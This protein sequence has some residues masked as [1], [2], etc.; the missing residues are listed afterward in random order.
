MKTANEKE[1][2][3]L[4]KQ[5]MSIEEFELEVP[6][7]S[8]RARELVSARKKK[9]N[10]ELNLFSALLAF[11]KLDLK[12]YHVGLTV[13]VMF[14]GMLYIKDP[15]YDAGGAANFMDVQSALSIS[16]NTVSVKSS[17][18]LTSIP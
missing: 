5:G 14:A 1:M 7:V 3:R 2:H 6:A 17:T 13:L 8:M 16:N 9:P 12:L 11:L 4:L 18:M 10:P 15:G